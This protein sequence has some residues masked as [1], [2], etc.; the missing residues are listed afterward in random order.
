MR[1][2][3][4][5]LGFRLTVAFLL[6]AALSLGVTA[7]LAGFQRELTARTRTIYQDRVVPL[8]QLKSIS[9]AYAISVVDAAHKRR[10]GELSS[11]AAAAGLAA[12]RDTIR[13][14]WTAYRATYLT[15]EEA[16]LAARADS[17]MLQVEPVLEGLR[18]AY[19][20]DNTAR[21]DSIAKM[22]LYPTV[23]PLSETLHNLVALQQR[24]AADEFAHFERTASLATRVAI[25]ISLVAFALAV[26]LGRRM[27]GQVVDA[28]RAMSATVAD[29]KARLQQLR[30]AL[31]DL[32]EGRLATVAVTPPRPVT[33]T[34]RDEVGAVIQDVNGMAENTGAAM[35]ALQT[36]TT[37]L[38][39][40]TTEIGKDIAL[41]RSGVLTV[42][43]DARA[44]PGVFGELA[45]GVRAIVQTI[46]EPIL[47]AE[48]VLAA[49]AA[50]DVSVRMAGRYQHDLA[51]LESAINRAVTNL[52]DAL[53]EV[54]ASAAELSMATRE[55]ASGA[56]ALA[57]GANRQG[58]AVES[59]AQRLREV[60]GSSE[61]NA[62]TAIEAGALVE[63]S[64]NAART[65]VDTA[66]ELSAAM[67]RMAEGS[68]ATGRIVH[69]IE[70]IA[71][72]TNLLALNAAVEAA[73]A[74]EAGRGFAVVAEEVRA[75]ASRSAAAARESTSLIEAAAAQTAS[76]VQLTTRMVAALRTLDER[77]EHISRAFTALA[78]ASSA[79][80][81]V[82]NAAATAVHQVEEVTQ[83]VAAA[84]EESASAAE[85]M[86]AQA[87]SLETLVGR[88]R[89]SA[90][91]ARH[92]D[93]AAD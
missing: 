91:R 26:L 18:T 43:A 37:R 49:V 74:G 69:S 41:A 71:F 90:G 23:D 47:E 25:G 20:T 3:H 56:V 31:G 2:S 48:S 14:Q 65:S 80:R 39:D 83:Q 32:A 19:A 1:W 72:Q 53:G 4:A 59:I 88:F 60:N 67:T 24:V 52:D 46:A 9:D 87:A 84:A 66:D 33:Y 85:E 35:A 76:G 27:A 28:L 68:A 55:I 40:A 51:E 16:R 54:A 30:G 89:R 62:R 63:E 11:E 7:T 77:M 81:D 86:R 22:V 70:E 79:Q 13:L 57:D 29:L 36:A 15:P 5:S 61:I 78:N 58:A 82:A 64:R 44:L 92:E 93:G 45:T 75:L 73:R 21:V 50:R 6:I 10:D 34:R 8:G 38:Q 12:A 42:R 17:Q